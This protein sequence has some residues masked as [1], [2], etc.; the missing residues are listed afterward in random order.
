MATAHA[1]LIRLDMAHLATIRAFTL[2]RLRLPRC[3]GHGGLAVDDGRGGVCGGGGGLSWPGVDALGF[4]ALHAPFF[5]LLEAG[6]LVGES[7]EGKW[8]ARK[9]ARRERREGG[10]TSCG[11]GRRVRRRQC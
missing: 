8:L 3:C 4:F 10:C 2:R 11:R 1:L 9:K 6:E 7:I 5:V